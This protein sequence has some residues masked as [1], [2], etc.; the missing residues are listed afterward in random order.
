MSKF[1]LEEKDTIHKR[2]QNMQYS[3]E[4]QHNVLLKP[5]TKTTISEELF[6]FLVSPC[7]DSY[8]S[9]NIPLTLITT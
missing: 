8:K 9:I 4:L 2:Q 3:L 7:I 1:T 5:S 6:A